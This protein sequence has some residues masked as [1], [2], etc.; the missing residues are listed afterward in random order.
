MPR[1]ARPWFRFY[2]EAMSDRKLRRIDP[3]CRWV[4]LGVLSLARMSPETGVLLVAVGQPADEHDLADVAGVTLKLTRQA[5][6]AFEKVGMVDRSEI[7][8]RVPAWASRQFESDDVTERTRKHRSKE[9]SNAVPGNAPETE[10]ETETDTPP[11]PPAERGERNRRRRLPEALAAVPPLPTVA[12]VLA[13]RPPIDQSL[14]LA[15]V[16]KLRH[17]TPD[18]AA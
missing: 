7:P 15:E 5:L 10:T 18:P 12:D 1:P 14:N 11:Q 9:R 2:V 3:A 4:W 13:D 16:A 6:D 17:R 8:W